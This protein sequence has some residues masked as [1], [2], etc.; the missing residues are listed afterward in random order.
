MSRRRK[1]NPQKFQANQIPLYIVLLPLA[2]FMSLPIIFI[3]CHAFK[4]LSELFA[5]PPTFWVKS[6][7]L[8][9]FEKLIETTQESGIALTRYIFNSL[10][11]T[12]AVML[13]SIFFGSMSSF[14]MSKMKFRGKNLLFEI[15]T[16]A[17]MFVPVAV[18]IPRYMVINATGIMNTY[19][20]HILPLVAMPVGVFLVKQFTDQ[21]PD[22]LIEAAV[23]D[24]ANYF[25]IYRKIILPLIKPAI[26]TV[27][28]LAFQ[29]A[30]GNTETSSM[31]TTKEGMRTLTFYMNTL[32]SGTNA[33][34]GQ[35]VSAAA[36]LIMFAPNLILFI[37]MQSKVMNTMA[38][39]GIK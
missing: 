3:I 35:G 31:Y 23:V 18:Q 34:A 6:P 11:V 39:S 5:Y 2:A 12:G 7:T 17:M 21:I 20:A 8:Y 15:N 38:Y 1:F 30:W 29:Q 9:N 10:V 26:A 33:V 14:A 22:S 24:G 25:T 28:I 19:L 37:L 13:M 36:S 27:A 16:L 4:P 32:A